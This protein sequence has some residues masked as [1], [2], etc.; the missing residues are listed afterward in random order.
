M[1]DYLDEDGIEEVT[2]K[3]FIKVCKTDENIMDIL[4]NISK[5]WID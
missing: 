1:F 2:K 4:Q 3:Q 5:D